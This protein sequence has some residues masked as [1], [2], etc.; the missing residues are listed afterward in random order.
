MNR[1]FGSSK[2]KAPKPTLTDAISSTDKRTTEVEEKIK[3]LD[4]ELTKYKTQMKG[5]REGPG[6]NLI[7]QR[8]M[9][10]LQQKRMYESQRDQLYQQSFNM[11]SASFA[12]E[13]IKNTMLTLT[14][15]QDA[16]KEMKRQYKNIDIDKIYDVQDE[17]A[18][19]LEQADEV[20]E[21]MGRSYNLPDD[22]DEM[23][24]EAELEALG[25]ELDLEN[26]LGNDIAE[27]EGGANDGKLSYLDD[28]DD[29]KNKDKEQPLPEVPASN[30]NGPQLEMA[31]SSGS[32]GDQRQ[33]NKPTAEPAYRI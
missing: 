6:K 25:D 9:R 16:N 24:L 11:E 12:T 19:L 10:V 14:A 21:L 20:Q 32:G 7:K 15:M 2:P 1:F 33:A 8:A 28:D 26:E 29:A 31:F 13:N 3:K 17:M 27:L 30:I 22:V 23:D 4:T 5:M 18:D